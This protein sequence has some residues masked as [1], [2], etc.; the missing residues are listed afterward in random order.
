MDSATATT[1]VNSSPATPETKSP[2]ESR[3]AS[4]TAP[5]E[6]E[7]YPDGGLKAWLTVFGAVL[8]LFCC[9]QLTAFGA[10]ETWYAANQLHNLPA[11]SISWIGSLQLW[12]LYAS[13]GIL[14]RIFDA[15]GPRVILIPGSMLLVV[16]TMLMS[17]CTKYYQFLLV[18]GLL[19]GL[20]YGM[21]FYPSFAS[22]STHFRKYRATA[23]G[24]AI[25][26]S[27]VGGVV[28]PIM[29]R[30]LF[31]S[32]GFG[33]AVRISGFLCLALCAVTCITVTSRIPPGQRTSKMIPDAVVVRDAPFILL[34]GGCLLVN[35]GLFIPFVYLADYSIYRGISSGTSFYIISAMNAGS[36]FGRIAPPFLAD[37]V[38][39]FNIA[40]PSTFLLGVLALSFWMFAKSL[41]AI[42][43]FAVVYGCFSGA[44]LAMQ[45][46]C[47]AQISKIEEV[48][49]R[50]GILY[51]V[52]SFGVLAGGPAAGALLKADHGLYTG[53]IILCGVVNILGSMLLLWAKC[54]VNP[55]I[56]TRV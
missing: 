34:V 26:G 46:P 41:I 22:I 48:G 33:W 25:A 45:I 16:S 15:Y 28:F 40:I 32:I 1:W 19:T 5:G 56:L 8:A 10:F 12:V 50:I 47:I 39:R 6:D 42:I 9:G 3:S 44:F 36:I 18:Q 51:S 55:Q 20:S 17:V 37:T 52:A 4:P 53:M 49:T 2:L 24:V 54:K 13:G 31:A 23:V 27:G 35:F 11:S 21:L 38:G 29:Y 30:Q 7:G 14:G 43:V